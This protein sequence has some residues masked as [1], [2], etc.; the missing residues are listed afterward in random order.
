[1]KNENIEK[2]VN[3]VVT[4]L[5]EGNTETIAYAVF[6]TVYGRPS[7]GWSFLNRLTMLMSSTK[8]ARGF[9]QWKKCSRHV[10]K[11]AKAIYILAPITFKAKRTNA[12]TGE[13]E[14]FLNEEDLKYGEGI[15]NLLLKATHKV[16]GNIG[17]YVEMEIESDYVRCV[18]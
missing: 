1:M 5:K 10:K 13:E 15:F 8:D 12:E 3:K 4:A 7:D 11:G 18:I 2:A 17:V 6:K 14:E 9:N 16:N